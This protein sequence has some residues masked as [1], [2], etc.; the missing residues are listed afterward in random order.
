[1]AQQSSFSIVYGSRKHTSANAAAAACRAHAFI[2][3]QCV[4]VCVCVCRYVRSSAE[5]GG[6]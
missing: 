3:A 2:A 1:M 6:P 4:C 5:N